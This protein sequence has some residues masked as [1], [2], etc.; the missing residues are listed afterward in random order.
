MPAS[1]SATQTPPRNA[2]GTEPMPPMTAATSA[3]RPSIAPI[4]KLTLP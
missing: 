3:F 2:P 1:T 4:E